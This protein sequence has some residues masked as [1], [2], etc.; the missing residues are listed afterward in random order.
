MY[1]FLSIRSQNHYIPRA[2]LIDLEPRVVNKLAHM[3]TYRKL[4]NP[5][6]LFV[7]Q[8][9]GGADNNWASGYQ[10]MIDR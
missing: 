1:L 2:L 6:N 7:A 8:E 10:H 3:G 5:K 4:F 9:G